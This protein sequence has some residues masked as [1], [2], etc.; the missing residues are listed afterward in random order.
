MARDDGGY[1]LPIHTGLLRDERWADLTPTQR[2]AWVTLFLLLDGEPRSGWFR[3]RA[4]VLWH[5]GRE[6]WREKDARAVVEALDAA[7]W[8]VPENADSPAVT[9]RGWNEY[10]GASARKAIY[11]QQRGDRGDRSEEYARRKQRR[12]QTARRETTGD[13]GRPR[14][15]ETRVS[16]SPS[17]A[18]AGATGD[19]PRINT[20]TKSLKEAMEDLGFDPTKIGAKRVHRKA[21]DVLTDE[22]EAV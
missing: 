2:G 21:A 20:G 5:L 7:G 3:D 11:N 4:R 14:R 16:S 19:G 10:T 17:P 12:S 6:G 15:D 22:P 18:G 9:L 8:L 13:S 1:W